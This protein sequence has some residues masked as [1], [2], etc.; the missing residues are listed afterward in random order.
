[1]ISRAELK[2]RSKDQLRGRWG[3]AIGVIFLASILIS[4]FNI[5]ENAK[6][7]Y[8]SMH[9]IGMNTSLFHASDSSIFT[10][11]NIVGNIWTLVLGG[12]F[13]L[14][15]SIFLL[16]FATGRNQA[17][18]GN[19]FEGFNVFLKTLGMY[20]LIILIAGLGMILLIVPGVILGLMYSQAFYIMADDNTKSITECMAESREMMVGHKAEL[21]VLYLSFIGWYILGAIPFGIG[22][23]W[24]NP[25]ASLT[26]T[27]YYLELKNEKNA[28]ESNENMY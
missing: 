5:S 12:V 28:N 24:V 26:Y 7:I 17:R 27:N 21:F 3:L 23:L 11:I 2:G 19:L 16:N 10:Q 18:V 13:T 6:D 20:L 15:Q 9:S 14:G 1:M 25:Y 8:N 4:G 22:L